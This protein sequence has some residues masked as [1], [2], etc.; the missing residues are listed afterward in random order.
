[1]KVDIYKANHHRFKFLTVKAGAELGESLGV[2]DPHFRT[3]SIVKQGVELD[4]SQFVKDVITATNDINSTGFHIYEL[5]IKVDVKI[6][7]PTR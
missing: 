7:S 2:T 3:V 6:E 5:N 4:D 1:M